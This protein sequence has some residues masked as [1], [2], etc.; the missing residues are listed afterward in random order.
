MKNLSSERFYDLP[1]TTQLGSHRAGLNPSSAHQSLGSLPVLSV[2]RKAKRE[3]VLLFPVK[4]H[5]E[6]PTAKVMVPSSRD[7]QSQKDAAP[8]SCHLVLQPQGSPRRG[9]HPQNPREVLGA[10]SL[11]PAPSPW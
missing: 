10:K 7:P 11:A 8:S 3:R 2:S 5:R 1:R 6:A 4:A 9:S